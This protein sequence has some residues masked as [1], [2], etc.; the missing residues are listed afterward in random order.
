MFFGQ[1]LPSFF[2]AQNNVELLWAE[3]EAM[4]GRGPKNEFGNKL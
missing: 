2:S 4:A 1:K 3:T